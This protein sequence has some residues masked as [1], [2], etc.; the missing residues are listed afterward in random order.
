[1]RRFGC[2]ILVSG[3][4]APVTTGARLATLFA[5]LAGIFLMHGLPAQS[6]AAGSGDM[7]TMVVVDHALHA[8]PLMSPGHG[9]PCVFT[10]PFRDHAPL[11][12]LVLLVV[13]TLLTVWWRPLLVG[14]PGRRGPPLAG[15]RLL[16]VVCVSRT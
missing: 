10:M 15:P 14:G 2:P 5:V 4:V 1:V 9:S 16:T 13:A 11:L 7:P 8:E 12:A 6:C 3:I